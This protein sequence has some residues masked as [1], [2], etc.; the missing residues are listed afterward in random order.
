MPP[1]EELGGREVEAEGLLVRCHCRGPLTLSLRWP[2]PFTTSSERMK[3]SPICPNSAEFHPVQRGA[4]P[5]L[6]AGLEARD[7]V[8]MSQ[9]PE[10][11]VAPGMQT[12]Y[13][14]GH[15]CKSCKDADGR[16]WEEMK[17][18]QTP[19]EPAL[20]VSFS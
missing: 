20:A 14:A 2:V 16:N 4:V 11:M 17:E 12:S 6:A 8:F 15:A 5:V 3:I 18:A 7:P 19:L 1:L 13:R 10:S 9:R